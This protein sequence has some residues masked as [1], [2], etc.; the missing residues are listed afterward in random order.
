MTGIG[1]KYSQVF[2][3]SVNNSLVRR[4]P[5]QRFGMLEKIEGVY[6][7]EHMSVQALQVRV[8]Q[9]LDGGFLELAVHPLGLPGCQWVVRFAL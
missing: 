3:S 2:L 6:E 7:G 1:F 4:F 8:V 5:S 9:G